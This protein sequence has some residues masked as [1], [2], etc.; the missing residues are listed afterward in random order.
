MELY[1]TFSVLIVLPSFFAYLNHRFLKLPTT[2]GIM[3][4]SILVSVLV[5]LFGTKVF[6]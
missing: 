1:Y 6:P 2:I 3:V 5:R 4:I